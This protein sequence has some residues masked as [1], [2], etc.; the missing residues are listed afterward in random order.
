MQ[1][2]PPTEVAVNARWR[3]TRR[4]YIVAAPVA[5]LLI[6]AAVFV[7]TLILRG[8]GST[9][10]QPSEDVVKLASGYERLGTVSVMG[11]LP[12]WSPDGRAMATYHDKRVHLWDLEEDGASSRDSVSIAGVQAMLWSPD[13]RTLAVYSIE[14]VD[15]YGHMAPQT[16]P[17]SDAEFL[18]LPGSGYVTPT[19]TLIGPDTAGVRHS[20]V[21]S[22]PTELPPHAEGS[23]GWRWVESGFT[24][25]G[26][27][28]G[29]RS[30]VTMTNLSATDDWGAF[31]SRS[32]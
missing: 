29:G 5:L 21:V 16:P 32:S 6:A 31:E 30:L 4:I 23:P 2:A 24:L 28:D 17:I 25:L 26:W 19:I 13:G 12:A 27:A 8:P 22:R 14:P 10:P 7:S 18:G 11:T 9:G 20:M 3:P 15:P 1:S